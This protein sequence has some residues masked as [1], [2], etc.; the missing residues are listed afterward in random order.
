MPLKQTNAN[1]KIKQQNPLAHWYVVV[2]IPSSCLHVYR[3]PVSV[4]RLI[5]MS[6][7]VQIG[8]LGTSYTSSYCHV[9]V[10]KL[11]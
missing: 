2:N 9:S 11:H 1:S 7:H 5:F 10:T 8:H 3:Y 6:N 4:R